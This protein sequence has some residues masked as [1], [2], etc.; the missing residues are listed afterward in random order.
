MYKR[1]KRGSE[2]EELSAGNAQHV[3]LSFVL[4]LDLPRT[5]TPRV[6]PVFG[7]GGATPGISGRDRRGSEI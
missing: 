5:N 1:I 4:G 3:A 2:D 7:C 6:T